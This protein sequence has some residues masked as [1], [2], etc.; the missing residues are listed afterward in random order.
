MWT[1]IVLPLDDNYK[2]RQT[3]SKLLQTTVITKIP[4]S[5]NFK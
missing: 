2:V 4:E 3:S 1:Q 5:G